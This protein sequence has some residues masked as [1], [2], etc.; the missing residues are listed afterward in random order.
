M[1][2]IINN[3]KIIVEYITED[4]MGISSASSALGIYPLVSGHS[5]GKSPIY[6]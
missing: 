5:Y 3:G 1:G 4:I 6:R 2:N